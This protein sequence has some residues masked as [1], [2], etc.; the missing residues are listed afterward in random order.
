MAKYRPENSK[1]QTRRDFIAAGIAAGAAAIGLTAAREIK[2]DLEKS[3][4]KEVVSAD[5]KE[6]KSE[7]KPEPKPEPQSEV[8]ETKKESTVDGEVA[9]AIE[10]IESG[11]QSRFLESPYLV[12][13][14][15]YSN[16]FIKKLENQ[17]SIEEDLTNRIILKISKKI[18]PEFR[19]KYLDYL[20]QLGE[21]VTKP[22]RLS[23]PLRNFSFGSGLNHTDA[24]DLFTE[25][26][27]DVMSASEGVVVLSQ[28]SWTKDNMLS[29]S[30]WLSGNYVIVFRPQEKEFYR[31][32]HMS[33]VDANVC[34]I[35][36]PGQKIGIVGH[37][38]FN[39]AKPG[40]GKHLHFEINEIG[41]LDNRS[42]N[43]NELTAILNSIKQ[44]SVNIRS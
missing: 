36:Y 18:T 37:A 11:D 7:P 6:V 2:K 41:P 25:E 21:N 1:E 42:K 3:E 31:Y 14:L 23:A 39:A 24:L 13:C 43:S 30:S 32:A 44:N 26:G 33:K 4:P 38:G 8:V 19:K 27:D 22:E 35:V 15:Y 5:R 12:S 20:D 16:A 28:K 40:H 34:D 17:A 9:K 29:T 10:I